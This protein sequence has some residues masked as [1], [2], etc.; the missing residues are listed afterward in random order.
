VIAV[1]G[2]LMHDVGKIGGGDI[3]PLGQQPCDQQCHRRLV[4]Q[5]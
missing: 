5:K 2:I 1:A 3:E 4:A